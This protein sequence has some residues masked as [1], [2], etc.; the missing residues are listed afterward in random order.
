MGR[1]PFWT[2]DEFNL[3]RSNT[4][5]DVKVLAEKLGRSYSSVANVRVRMRR[6]AQENADQDTRRSGWYEETV[7][8]PL[9]EYK[10]A[11]DAWKH[12][13]RYVEF[14]QVSHRYSMLGGVVLLRCRRDANAP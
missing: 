14:E 10:P 12:Y 5:L 13:H 7:G 4:D 8:V 2:E 3:V 11:F 1:G 6:E 9:I